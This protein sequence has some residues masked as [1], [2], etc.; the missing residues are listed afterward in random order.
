MPGWRIKALAP[1][2]AV[3]LVVILLVTTSG[4]KP[5]PSFAQGPQSLEEADTQ[6]T[7]LPPDTGPPAEGGAATGPERVLVLGDS[8]ARQFGDGLVAIGTEK[9]L[10]V[11]NKAAL[12]CAIARGD[13]VRG[14]DGELPLNCPWEQFWGEWTEA[15][16]PDYV[17]IYTGQFDIV[18]KHVD[19]EWLSVGSDEFNDYFLDELEAVRETV[20]ATGAR[21][22]L[23]TSNY[24][25][26][27]PSPS[28]KTAYH[29]ENVDNLNNML[30]DF[31]A[32]HPDDVTVLDLNHFISPDGEYTGS[33]D[34]IGDI[35]ESDRV[36]FNAAGQA[37]IAEWLA[38]KLPKVPPPT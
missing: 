14:P 23:L 26:P 34:G 36:H 16:Q 24:S 31:A 33:I 21:L 29:D 32:E 4:A 38:R 9:G 11:D 30:R 18:D 3:S 20:T 7:E 12:G 35:R 2:A 19:G 6:T 37:Y 10:A 8:V 22:V 13:A 27:A 5:P 17:V 28:G 1:A 25:D 15:W